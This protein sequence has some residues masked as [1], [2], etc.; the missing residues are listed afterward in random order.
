MTSIW[1][2]FGRMMSIGV[3]CVR[4]SGIVFL[5]VVALTICGLTAA[6][7]TFKHDER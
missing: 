3:R 7:E 4:S 6:T 2:H 5:L 1:H